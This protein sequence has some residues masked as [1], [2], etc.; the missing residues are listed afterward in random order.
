MI[1]RAEL[2]DQSR[3][4]DLIDENEQLCRIVNASVKTAKTKL[5]SRAVSTHLQ[6]TNDYYEITND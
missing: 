3:L 1:G 5:I 4:N 6:I 2:M